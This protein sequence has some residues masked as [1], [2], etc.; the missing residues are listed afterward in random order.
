M[1]TGMASKREVDAA[2]D[3]ISYSYREITLLH[4][5][6]EYPATN[7]NLAQMKNL[8][9]WCF[10]VGLSDH[11]IGSQVAVMA[12]GLGAEVI[13]K[14]ICLDSMGL[15]GGFAMIPYMFKRMVQDVRA[16]KQLMGE[17][18]YAQ[19]TTCSPLRPSLYYSRDIKAGEALT[20]SDFIIA[21]PG[22]GAHPSRLHEF[23][24]KTLEHDVKKHDPSH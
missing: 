2:L 22:L 17:A 7:H 10:P 4:C 6:S 9:G 1:S 21:R 11:S 20:D 18:E 3:I 5:V 12:A 14:H 13:E 8:N 19:E 23:I 24:G 15:D 16:V